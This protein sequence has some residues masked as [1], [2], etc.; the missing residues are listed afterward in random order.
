MIA[1]L[2]KEKLIADFLVN[3]PVLGSDTP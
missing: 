2:C 1:K 3:N